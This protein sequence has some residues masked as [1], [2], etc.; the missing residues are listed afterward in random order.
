MK[1]IIVGLSIAASLMCVNGAMAAEMPEVAKAHHCDSCHA[2]DV[3]VVG[4]A[5]KAVAEKYRG[6]AA[7][8]AYLTTKISKGGKG[9]W[10]T[11]PMPGN[12]P[13]GTKQA[14]MKELVRFIL[15]L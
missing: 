2:I 6:D 4:P 1:K 3:R 13:A 10:G 11:M 9:V 8:P 7:A 5:W 12:D 15:A 14:D